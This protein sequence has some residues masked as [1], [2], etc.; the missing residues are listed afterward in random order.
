MSGLLGPDGNP[1][2]QETGQD[3]PEENGELFSRAVTAF[4]AWVTPEGRVLLTDDLS[5][6][7]VTERKPTLDDIIGMAANIGAE[8]S[9]RRTAGMAARDVVVTQAQLAEAARQQAENAAVQDLIAK[10]GQFRG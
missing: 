5:R 3:G 4:L 7:L 2:G 8:A 1:V 10:D 9:G 6:P